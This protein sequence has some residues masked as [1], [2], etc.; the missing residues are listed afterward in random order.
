MSKIC[1]KDKL[2]V[3]NHANFHKLCRGNFVATLEQQNV[4]LYLVLKW[5]LPT[6]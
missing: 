1:S 4:T 3:S 5:M 2:F 6:L